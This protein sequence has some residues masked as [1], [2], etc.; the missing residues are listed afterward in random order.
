M[1]DLK[2]IPLTALLEL[3]TSSTVA[4]LALVMKDAPAGD[5]EKAMRQLTAVQSEVVLRRKA[6]TPGS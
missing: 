4:F 6:M 3:L 2:S 1:G 5:L